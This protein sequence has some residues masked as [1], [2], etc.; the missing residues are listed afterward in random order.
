MTVYIA[1]AEP[2]KA[3]KICA[4]RDTVEGNRPWR[5]CGQL[6]CALVLLSTQS[7]DAPPQILRF[8]IIDSLPGVA[9]KCSN[10]YNCYLIH[11]KYNNIT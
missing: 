4:M 3:Y 8:L 9:F 6:L 2:V 7:I 10:K 11:H 1:P 5:V